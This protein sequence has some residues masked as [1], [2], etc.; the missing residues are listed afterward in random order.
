MRLSVS[1]LAWP[2]T[3]DPAFLAI[4]RADRKSVV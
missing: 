3:T 2:A 4:L 1:A